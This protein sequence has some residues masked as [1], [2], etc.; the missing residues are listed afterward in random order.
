MSA[1]FALLA[2]MG[3]L[4]FL[5]GMAEGIGTLAFPHER[6]TIRLAFGALGALALVAASGAAVYYAYRLDTIALGCLLALLPW[7]VFAVSPLRRR[8]AEKS[9][10]QALVGVEKASPE[11]SA[12][13]VLLVLA[14]AADAAALRW[15]AGAAT[16]EAIRS[17][18]EV[19]DPIYFLW[20]FLAT[21]CL[22]AL[23]YRRRYP[24]LTLAAGSFHLFTVLAPAL[25]V[26]RIGYGFD[27]FIHIASEKLVAAA[28]AV[29]PKTPWYIGQ[30]VLVTA[31]SKLGH[32]PV[33]MVDRWLL[34]S[35]T[36]AFLPLSAAWLLRRGYGV[37]RGLTVLASLGVLLLPLSSFVST[38]PQGLA[39][40]FLL[41]LAVLGAAWHHA[42]R[43]PLPF[44]LLL[45]AAA[46]A[47]HP[48]AG[49]PA[50]VFL[51]FLMFFKLKPWPGNSG[52]AAKG[53]F[54]MVLLA[55][56]AAAV[57]AA[58]SA[59][60]KDASGSPA[61]ASLKRP[62][63]ELL[64][65]LPVEA[66]GVES[67]FRPALDFA[68]AVDRNYE[69]LL[70]L[71]VAAGGWLLLRRRETRRTALAVAAA[72]GALLVSVVVLK[73]GYA[74]PDVIAYEQGNYGDRLYEATLLLFAPLA[75][76]AVAWW[77]RALGRTDRGVR[78][79]QVLLFAA[80]ATSL[81]YAAFPRVDDFRMTRGWSVS[82][83][84]VAAVRYVDRVGIAPYVVLA[85]QSVSA[86]AL[87]EFGFRT[88]YG[89]QF[90][91]PI[92][93]GAPLYGFYLEMVYGGAKRG[94]M[95]AAMRSVNVPRAF[96]IVNRYWTGS[97]RIVEEAKKTADRWTA[98]DEGEAYVFEYS[99][100]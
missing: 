67:R 49:I 7:A 33:E 21:A 11:D 62:I 73:G 23:A 97:S 30:Y 44:L 13:A 20:T 82:R 90:Y 19:V 84:D 41:L 15:L 58:F 37:P 99:L 87:R 98:I 45:A 42:H 95:E 91:Y 56:G 66:P 68:E 80:V 1:P 60:G 94:T 78:V 17:P 29:T 81:G 40:L 35:L 74:F 27:P 43:P 32:L 48:L 46:L 63:P 76:A 5:W 86:A 83:H 50:A 9:K 12:S 59:A 39:N 77:W 51:T 34:P 92:P 69:T 31:A 10:E 93:T 3:G 24:H 64:L 14:L 79:F 71:L 22:I 28:G 65:R 100:R 16:E 52:L 25:I 88:Y 57:P 6:R 70:L 18:W 96:F 8:A 75:L 26:Y 89:D 54:L 47:T 55:A 38:A 61:F 53:F 72:G 36:A 85:N 4:L 2:P